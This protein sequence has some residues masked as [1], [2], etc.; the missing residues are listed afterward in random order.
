M[1]RHFAAWLLVTGLLSLPFSMPARAGEQT[2]Q[3][4][5][6]N[7]GTTFSVAVGNEVA[8]VTFSQSEHY[9]LRSKPFSIG[10]RFVSSAATL[11]IDGHFAAF[12]SSGRI[13][14]NQCKLIES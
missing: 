10:H 6:C 7:D 11:I 12:V 1:L 9:R 13:D 8:D 14:L 2:L 5:I 4:F 3:Q